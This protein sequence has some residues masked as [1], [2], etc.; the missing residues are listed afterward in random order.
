MKEVVI[1]SAVRTPIGSFGGCFKTV[2]AVD[3]QITVMQEVLNRAGLEAEDLDQLIF[4]NIFAHLD[5]NVSRLAALTMGLPDSIPGFT[6]SSACISASLAIIQGCNAI[7][8]GQADTVMAGGTESMSNAPYI[9][10]NC[11][12]GQGL[13]HE[14]A[15][16]AIWRSMQEYPIGGGMG[17]AAER[18]AE[19]YQISREEQDELSVTSH[20]RA[21]RAVKEGRFRKE[22]V[23]YEVSLPRGKKNVVVDDEGPRED[24][25]MEKLSTLPAVFKEGGTVTAANAS[26]MNDGAAAVV[27]MSAAKAAERGLTP[28]ATIKAL[29]F[30]GVDPFLVGIAPVPAVKSVLEQ[31][32][33]SLA[34][35]ELFEINEAFASYYIATEKELGLNREITNVNGSGISIG[36]PVGAT[37]TRMVVSLIHEMERRGVNLGISALCGG[38]GQGT[39]ILLER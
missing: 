18:L 11:R 35:I 19:K 36:H 22:I 21:V 38:G 34:D 27:L 14:I 17:L 30:V 1:V 28:L 2:K 10:E 9:L 26:S 15:V 24:T 37:G 23:P 20:R 25:R 33:H 29:K 8:L 13:R 32:G 6:I 31:T 5:Q 4:G 39:A 7:A 12:W 16:D 3:L